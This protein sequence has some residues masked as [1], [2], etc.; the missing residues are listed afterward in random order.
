MKENDAV[1][2]K[3]SIPEVCNAGDKGKISSV[4]YGGAPRCYLVEFDNPSFEQNNYP[5]FSVEIEA[6]G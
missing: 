4:D 3:V 5:F 6:A 1:I 2:I